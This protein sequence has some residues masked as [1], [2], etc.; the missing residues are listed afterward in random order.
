M[1]L[2]CLS[3]MNCTLQRESQYCCQGRWPSRT[4]TLFCCNQLLV[5]SVVFWIIFMSECFKNIP[6]AGSGLMSASLQYFFLLHVAFILPS[7][8]FLCLWS[9]HIP[10][11]W[12]MR[13]LFHCRDGASVITGFIDM[14][15]KVT[16]MVVVNFGL[17]TVNDF[18]TYMLMLVSALHFVSGILWGICVVMALFL[19]LSSHDLTLLLIFVPYCT[20][21]QPHHFIQRP[22]CQLYLWI[23]IWIVNIFLHTIQLGH[24]VVP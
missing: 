21:K 2:G 15:P 19:L 4:L 17:I 10:K 23:F 24:S 7:H 3:C 13:S 22:V 9:S 14:S 11:T 1:F 18:A 16:F 5:N 8:G 20:L 6:C 12:A